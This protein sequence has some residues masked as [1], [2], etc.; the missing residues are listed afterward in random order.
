MASDGY[1]YRAGLSGSGLLVEIDVIRDGV[2]VGLVQ[3]PR[4][5]WPR[6]VQD[7]SNAM[8]A[9]RVAAQIDNIVAEAEQ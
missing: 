1:E 2:P 6:I 9:A 8:T 7:V 4:G 3:I 5:E